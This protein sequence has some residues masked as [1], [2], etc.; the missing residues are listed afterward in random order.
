MSLTQQF[1]L[2]KRLCH[3]VDACCDNSSPPVHA[4]AT[5]AALRHAL[6]SIIESVLDQRLKGRVFSFEALHLLLDASMGSLLL[7]QRCCNAGPGFAAAST[8]HIF[9]KMAPILYSR[10]SA[11]AAMLDVPVADWDANVPPSDFSAQLAAIKACAHSPADHVDKD[12]SAEGSRLFIE[13]LA[14]LQREPHSPIVPGEL[15]NLI[16][17]HPPSAHAM[18][19]ARPPPLTAAIRFATRLARRSV[20]SP[21]VGASTP[22]C[23]HAPLACCLRPSK[24]S[25]ASSVTSRCVRR[26]PAPWCAR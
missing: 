24:I 20:Q 13:M 17:V 22:A 18:S 19:H 10:I 3:A 8:A 11:A 12:A 14:R 21:Q 5:A 7:I 15:L 1:H 9:I 26:S 23:S 6:R 2:L 4:P 25:L 16:M